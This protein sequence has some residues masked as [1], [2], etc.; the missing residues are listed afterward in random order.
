LCS[1]VCRARREE[2]AACVDRVIRGG[3]LVLRICAIGLLQ[4]A[5]LAAALAIAREANRRPTAPRAEQTRSGPSAQA[6]VG[7][8]RAIRSRSRPSAAS[9]TCSLLHLSKHPGKAPATQDAQ[10]CRT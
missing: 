2:E 9:A 3:R 7:A 6:I 10:T 8:I 4:V 5:A 1:F